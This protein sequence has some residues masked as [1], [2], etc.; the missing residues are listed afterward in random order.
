MDQTLSGPESTPAERK[1]FQDLRLVAWSLGSL[2]T[3]AL[4]LVLAYGIRSGGWAAALSLLWALGIWSAGLGLG[5]LFG[6]PKV[7]QGSHPAPPP[8]PPDQ[9]SGTDGMAPSTAGAAAPTALQ[10]Y[11]QRVNTNLEEI[12]DWLTKIIVGVTLVQL[13]DI[14][15]LVSRFADVIAGGLPGSPRG[16]GL[17]I[18]I[19]FAVLGFLFGYLLTRLYIQGALAR[20]ERNLA[21]DGLSAEIERQTAR[22]QIAAALLKQATDGLESRAPSAAA[23]ASGEPPE[24]VR[25]ELAHLSAEYQSIQIPDLAARTRAKTEQAARLFKF[26]VEKGVSRDW[27]AAQGDEAMVL[28]LAGAVQASPTPEDAARLLLAGPRVTRKHVQYWIVLA[29][30]RLL[31]RNM[32]TSE[33]RQEIR[34]LLD[35]Y[36]RTA[37]DVLRRLLNTVRGRLVRQSPARE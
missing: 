26:A 13:R 1:S 20:A 7:L 29:L 11:Q 33:Q 16:F 5:F 24:E 35:L 25:A 34:S 18:I 30:E 4:V 31:E 15:P 10:A 2:A 19:C 17:A 23:D 27:L 22:A 3:F 36:D 21:G 9:P 28:A 32:V 6:I 8:V 12:S 14:P 37:D